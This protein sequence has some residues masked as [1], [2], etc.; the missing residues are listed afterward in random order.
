[1]TGFQIIWN[2]HYAIEILHNFVGDLKILWN[3]S[4]F[5]WISDNG[6]I[7]DNDQISDN[8]RIPDNDQIIDNQR[9]S[10]N[11]RISDFK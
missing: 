9:V 3:H 7:S 11:E 5:E 1:M 2:L 6:L 4:I 10:E 8:Q